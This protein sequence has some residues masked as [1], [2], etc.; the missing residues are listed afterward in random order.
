MSGDADT[1]VALTA[2]RTLAQLLDLSG[3]SPVT[4]RGVSPDPTIARVF[5]GQVAAQA[6]VAAARTVDPDRRV[7]SLHAYFLQRGDG[8]IPLDY[9]V[10]SLRDSRS[11]STRRVTARQGGR[12]IF[13]MMASF[14]PPSRG[15]AHQTR[16]V[17]APDP[18]SL[19]DSAEVFRSSDE[20]SKVWYAGFSRRFPVDVR[21]VGE[22]PRVSVARG[23]ATPPASMAWIRAA[24]P[25]PDDPAI[26]TAA[27]AYM[28]DLFLLS[29]ALSPHGFAYGDEGL[30]VASL[31]H[32]VWFHAPFR[33]DDW[34]LY[35]EEG[36][37]AEDGRALCRGQLFDRSGNLIA[38]VMQEGVIRVPR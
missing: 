30:L 11:Y 9:E 21:F 38:S 4:F 22:P 27:L 20:R 5:G 19:P 12:A 33:A 13:E 3:V 31:D 34:L 25:L 10:I 26:H 2:R 7:H 32:T 14:Q 35:D 8:S 6:L 1:S 36:F 24:D 18:E 16:T 15:I 28:S 29:S 23:I 37:W 17:S